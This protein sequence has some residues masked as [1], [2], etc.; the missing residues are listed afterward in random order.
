MFLALFDMDGTLIDS[1]A[2]IVGA[3]TQA[4]ETHGH[5]APNRDD[6]T[7]IVGLSL[8]QALFRLAPELPTDERDTLVEAYKDAFMDLRG[9]GHVSPMYPGALACLDDLAATDGVVL[10]IATGKSRRGVDAVFEQHDLAQYFDTVQVADDHPS[11]P[12][13]SMARAAVLQTG[14]SVS[15]MIGD[16]TYD[17]EMGRS[18]GMHTIGVTWG[19]HSRNQLAPSS[20]AI[21]TSFSQV[22]QTLKGLMQP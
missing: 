1:Q 11:K 18:A 7:T 3:M 17:V 2:H 9:Q 22:T 20:D 4:F 15:T 21:C 10:G 16:T 12:H 13:P 14:A 5:S 6:V 8:P 19:Y